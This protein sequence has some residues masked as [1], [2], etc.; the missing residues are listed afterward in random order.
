M[1]PFLNFHKA[2]SRLAFAS[3]FFASQTSTEGSCQAHLLTAF[4][5]ALHLRSQGLWLLWEF[6]GDRTLAFYLRR[7][8]GMRLLAED[9]GVAP[10]SAAA[11]AMQQILGALRQLHAA[12]VVHRDIKPLNIVLDEEEA[13]FRIIDLGAAADL[14]TGMNYTPDE[15]ILDVNYC[16]PELYVLPTDTVD[17][18]EQVLQWLPG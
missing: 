13:T 3:S 17:L 1:L 9:L 2:S 16:A 11:T 5:Q 8:D 4:P 12:R 18:S 14:R 10:E 7:R 15:S 6:R